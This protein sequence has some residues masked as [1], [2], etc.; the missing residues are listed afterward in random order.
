M[1]ESLFYRGPLGLMPNRAAML[2]LVSR[3]A[4]FRLPALVL[5]AAAT[6]PAM[7]GADE[8]TG[9]QIYRQMC[10]RCHGADGEGTKKEYPEPLAGKKS[11]A[12]LAR[13]IAKS[14]PE[15]DPGK[16]KGP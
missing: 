5:L 15:D 9:A 16:L 6:C 3:A 4:A 2:S 8:L 14:M 7:A 1:M 13:Y 12:Q 10:A 11:L